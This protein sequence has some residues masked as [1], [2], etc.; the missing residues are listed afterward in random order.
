V[1]QRKCPKLPMKVTTAIK[2]EPIGLFS[3]R[4][5]LAGTKAGIL[6]VPFIDLVAGK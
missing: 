5:Q 3:V 1:K 2:V 6:N 4:L